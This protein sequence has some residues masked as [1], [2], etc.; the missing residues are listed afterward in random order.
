MAKPDPRVL[1]EQMAEAVENGDINVKDLNAL[2][3]EQIE[4]LQAK[5]AALERKKE[6]V[7]KRLVKAREEKHAIAE[8]QRGLRERVAFYQRLRP[9][10][11]G[12]VAVSPPPA[13]A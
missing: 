3:R 13:G 10:Q 5:D 4:P 2:L 7:Q 1:I 9:P 6:A 12:D 11:M 8:E